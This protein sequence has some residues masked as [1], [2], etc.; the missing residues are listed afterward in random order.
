VTIIGRSFKA[1]SRADTDIAGG[2]SLAHRKDPFANYEVHPLG[3][4][5]LIVRL[6]HQIDEVFSDS[7]R[8][9][10]ESLESEPMPGVVEVVPAFSSLA[11]YYDPWII[12]HESRRSSL[13]GQELEPYTYIERWMVQKIEHIRG[14]E[15]A[16][17]GLKS[18]DRRLIE[19]PVCYGGEYGPDLSVLAE[20]AQLTEQAVVQ[21]HS[22]SSYRVGMIGFTPGFPYMLGLPEQLA[23][24][25]KA[26]PRSK[27]PAGSVG[28]AGMQTGIYPLETPGG[29]Q[30]I[31]RTPLVLFNPSQSPPSLLMPGDLVRYIPITP[32]QF[33][34]YEGE[35]LL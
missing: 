12:Y 29:W 15:Q 10:K 8:L 17:A 22:G 25:R 13:D 35:R 7:I 32:E 16:E 23:A 3:D 6:S 19:I 1:K 18:D 14:Q 33:E 31:G 4:K 11:V 2:D 30:I 21:L 27:V 28:I 24:A 5:G 9:L 20:Q 34:A 26:T